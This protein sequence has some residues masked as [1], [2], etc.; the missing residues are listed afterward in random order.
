MFLERSDCTAKG[1][2][3]Q[4]TQVLTA[5]NAFTWEHRE[6]LQ[7][8]ASLIPLHSYNY[9]NQRRKLELSKRKYRGRGYESDMLQEDALSHMDKAFVLLR[10]KQKHVGTI[11]KCIKS[12][13]NRLLGERL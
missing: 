7:T 5:V 11:L 1:P 6:P 12:K 4:R 2:I 13:Q 8:C 10:F 3:K 9:F